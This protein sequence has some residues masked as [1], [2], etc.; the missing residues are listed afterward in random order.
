MAKDL[1]ASVVSVPVG[2]TPHTTTSPCI[3]SFATDPQAVPGVVAP[4]GSL[5]IRTDAPSIYVKDG[6]NAT[7]WKLIGFTPGSF[8]TFAL[9]GNVN[10]PLISGPVNNH[11]FSGIDTAAIIRQPVDA[12]G[13]T[14]TGLNAGAQQ[15]NG[16]YVVIENL[17]P[18]TLTLLHQD[19]GS[20]PANQFKLPGNVAM[21]VPIDGAVV[22]IYDATATSQKWRVISGAGT[23]STSSVLA[24][25]VV[26]TGVVTAPQLD[27]IPVAPN[28]TTF[29]NY[30]AGGLLASA[31]ILR[32]PVLESLP[33]TLPPK[34]TGLV[35]QP[36]GTL[37]A[38]QNV[39][40]SK[41]I[42]FAHEH[43][44][45]TDANRINLPDHNDWYLPPKG[46]LTLIYDG[47]P[48]PGRLQRWVPFAFATNRFPKEGINGAPGVGVGEPDP[49]G[50]GMRGS[51]AEQGQLFMLCRGIPAMT[52][53]VNNASSPNE[54]STLA[55]V[56][57]L[58]NESLT[59]AKALTHNS[60]AADL[61]SQFRLSGVQNITAGSTISPGPATTII[62]LTASVATTIDKMAVGISPTPGRVVA[63]IN[64]SSFILSVSHNT[65]LTPVT[66]GFLLP[67]GT[68]LQINPNAVLTVWYDDE[69]DRWRPLSSS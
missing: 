62:R 55:T 60:D 4:V 15:G 27:A 11:T 67:N 23:T 34:I 43:A 21:T 25:Q 6:P 66:D 53:R 7:S 50:N 57:F 19:G 28:F 54:I 64:T 36:P 8:S 29:N 56:P 42:T 48:E 3:V 17:G 5:G 10:A 1:T 26:F 49:T 45:S 38:I 63:L 61:K 2:G 58:V 24:G 9:T 68:Q 41:F 65:S 46:T 20:A 69:S 37:L 59:V 18:G 22:C 12:G 32:Q 40:A 44:S 51:A 39:S 16:A 52:L 14:V 47:G 13:A 31:A 33:N 30:N 35:A